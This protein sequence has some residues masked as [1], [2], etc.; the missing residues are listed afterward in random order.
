MPWVINSG[1]TGACRGAAGNLY[2]SDGAASCDS[3][4]AL[5]N[6][7]QTIVGAGAASAPALLLNGSVYTGGTGT[8][9]WSMLL[10]QKSGTTKST[11]S[12]S[13]TQ[14]GINAV[15]GFAGNL[16]DAGVA[17]TT[18]FLVDASGDLTLGGN[19]TGATFIATAA[20]PTTT[21]SNIGYGNSTAANT[22]CGFT[23]I[24]ATGCLVINIGGTAHYIPYN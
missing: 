4:G 16:I 15:S 9:T 24:T 21:G 2:I 5:T 11:W 6:S 13:G 1:D 3:N 12:T 19:A 17:G 18:Y 10:V 22:N 7:T 23:V 14:L 20:T 8:T